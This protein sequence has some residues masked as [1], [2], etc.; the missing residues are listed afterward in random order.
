MQI[1]SLTLL[2]QRRISSFSLAD[3]TRPGH[4]RFIALWLVDPEQRIISTANVPP[5]QQDW[6][7]DA[8]INGPNEAPNEGKKQE[9][10]IASLTRE[11]SL[12]EASDEGQKG[13]A[14]GGK[15]PP[16]LMDIV[17]EEFQDAKDK[18]LMS[19]EEAKEHRLKLIGV[20]TRSVHVGHAELRSHT[21]NFSEH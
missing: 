3:R 8:I 12:K 14:A 18:G 19:V 9:S 4:R 11:L 15:L 21:Y 5:Q 16:E 7:F 13:K 6:W 10:G 20:K 17:W 2:S 1:T